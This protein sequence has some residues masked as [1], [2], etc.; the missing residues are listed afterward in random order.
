[1][2]KDLIKIANLLD[3]RGLVKEADKLDLI[4]KKI[5]SSGEWPYEEE[6]SEDMYSLNAEMNAEINPDEISNEDYE[7]NLLNDDINYTSSPESTMIS[8]IMAVSKLLNMTDQEFDDLFEKFPNAMVR[9][10]GEDTM[11]PSSKVSRKLQKNNNL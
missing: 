6:G 11:S 10:F 9:L 4:I 1:M 7:A 2:I 5:A 3:S 8:R